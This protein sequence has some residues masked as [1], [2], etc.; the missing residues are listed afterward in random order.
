MAIF[1]TPPTLAALAHDLAAGRTTARALVE[2]CLARIEEPGGDGRR[3][4]LQVD[5]AGARAA[6]DAMDRLR[7]AGAAL[8]PFAGIP[9][10]VKDLFDVAGQV[11]RA[12]SRALEDAPPAARDAEAVARMRRAGFVVIGRVNMTEFAFSGLGLNPHYGTP[13]NPRDPARIP[14]GSS[15]GS[16]VAVAAGMAYAALG[17]D[18]GGSCRIPAAFTGVVGY[19]PTTARV[20]RSGVFP[21]SGTLDSVGPLARSVECCA[22]VDAILVGETLP[23]L[24]TDGVA[25]LR[26]GVPQNFLLDGMDKTVAGAFD[27]ALRRLAAAGARIEKITL[28]PLDE[29]TAINARG[30][31]GSAES[32]AIH[33]RLI[34]TRGALYDPRVLV[35]IRRGAEQSAA[36]YLDLVAARGRFVAAVAEQAARFDALLAPTVPIVPPRFDELESDADY[37][38]ING[39]VLRNP[40]VVNMMDGCAL[41]IPMHED[42]EMPAGLMVAGLTGTDR[43]LF[44][45][46]AAVEAVLRGPDRATGAA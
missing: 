32:W 14:G 45:L 2:D 7:A 9:L 6:A 30:G 4:F 11:T 17:T 43:R 40:A 19:K 1:T 41:S 38:R 33:R 36:D 46:G 23:V 34:E 37:A 13:K 39:L 26:L 20:P 42:G 29:L 5:A 22:I 27:R 31:F 18:T 15:S 44:A 3:T 28:P 24:R 25:G 16:A 12:G 8:S 35:R 10:A 21:L